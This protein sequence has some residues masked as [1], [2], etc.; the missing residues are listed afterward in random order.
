MFIMG[1][2]F[3]RF[4]LKLLLS[5]CINISFDRRL[6]ERERMMKFV[7]SLDF[8]WLESIKIGI[9]R[10]LFRFYKWSFEDKSND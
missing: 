6:R 1:N 2:V 4:W 3:V 9:G 5:V 8:C 10:Y 7:C